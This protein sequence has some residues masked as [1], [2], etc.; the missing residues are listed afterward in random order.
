MLIWASSVFR[1][2]RSQK[3]PQSTPH[4]QSTT[5]PDH[6]PFHSPLTFCFYAFRLNTDCRAGRNTACLHRLSYPFSQPLVGI[7]AIATTSLSSLIPNQGDDHRVEV[8]E[9]H[10]QVK[11][12]LNE[13]LLLVHVQLAEDLRRVEEVL[14]IEYPATSKVDMSAYAIIVRS[15][16]EEAYRDRP[17][18][19]YLVQGAG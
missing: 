18:V 16:L 12:E 3:T 2:L 17:I 8:E 10:E 5:R 6:P 13:R 14:V 11:A 9:E 1:R 15:G 4:P 19:S 7:A